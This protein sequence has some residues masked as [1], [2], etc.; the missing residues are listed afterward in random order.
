MKTIRQALASVAVALLALPAGAAELGDDG[1]HKQ[2]FFADT[3]LDMAE[4]LADAMAEG[5]DLMVIVEQNGCPY[6][7]E[8]HEVNFARDDIVS[9][10][11]ENFYVVQ[12][13]LWGAREVTDFDGETMEERDLVRKW[14][15]SFTPTTLFF[16]WDAPDTPPRDMREALVFTVPGYFKPFH[17]LSSLEYV[18]TDGYVDQ[19]N[20]QRWLQAKGDR[21][22]E[23]GIEVKVWE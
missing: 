4:D 2:P 9:S 18:A 21:M 19:P 20:F 13:D 23:Q 16:A 8:M 5:K 15:V 22:R 1:L 11:Q 7:R 3:F 12:L 6:C 17:H 14:H 10:I